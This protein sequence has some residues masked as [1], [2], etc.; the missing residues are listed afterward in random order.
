MLYSVDSISL[1]NGVYELLVRNRL[2]G[3]SHVF[4]ACKAQSTDGPVWSA[5]G[6]SKLTGKKGA[7][8]RAL[9]MQQLREIYYAKRS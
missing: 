4:Y 2:T 6:L 7:I 1:R 8:E 5:V 3:A 9:N